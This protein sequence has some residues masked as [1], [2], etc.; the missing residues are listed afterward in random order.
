MP[1][2]PS[3]ATP[4][5]PA[6]CRPMPASLRTIARTPAWAAS[7]AGYIPPCEPQTTIASRA[8]SPSWVAESTTRTSFMGPILGPLDN[9]GAC[10]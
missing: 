4:A 3:Q 10:Y 1:R 9:A 2:L 5:T 8:L 6:W 7:H